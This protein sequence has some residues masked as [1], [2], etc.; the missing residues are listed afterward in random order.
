MPNVGIFC[1]PNM[2]PY[3]FECKKWELFRLFCKKKAWHMC[4]MYITTSR[5]YRWGNRTGL[6]PR[7]FRDLRKGKMSSLLKFLRWILRPQCEIRFSFFSLCMAYLIFLNETFKEFLLKTNLF[8]L[9]ICKTIWMFK[10]IQNFILISDLK[11]YF[12]KERRLKKK[13]GPFFLRTWDS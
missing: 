2:S 10:K 9:E 4:V 6:K 11:N 7:M 5:T 3:V 8:L 12:R 1:S 13:S